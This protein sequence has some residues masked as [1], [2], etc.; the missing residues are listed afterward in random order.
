MSILTRLTAG[1]RMKDPREGQG[2]TIIETTV[3]EIGLAVGTL[4]WFSHDL[5]MMQH[6]QHTP[7]NYEKTIK[8]ISRIFLDQWSKGKGPIQMSRHRVEAIAEA[9]WHDFCTN[10]RMTDEERAILCHMSDR[11]FRRGTNEVYRATLAELNSIAR[12]AYLKV[13]RQLKEDI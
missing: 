7:P 4:D 13:K 5:V 3:A 1:A 10:Q 12:E 2:T 11:Q 6:C 9:I 8:Q